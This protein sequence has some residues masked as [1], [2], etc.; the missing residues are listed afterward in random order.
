MAA[1][2]KKT[3]ENLTQLCRIKCTEAEQEKLLKDL[4]EIL[5]YVEQLQEVDTDHVKPCD[6][7]LEGIINVMREDVV[8]ETLPR[9]QF[10]ANA[11]SHIGGLIRVPP[12]I[13]SN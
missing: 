5:N 7:V 6:H 8:G 4:Q 9:E 1:L 11:P 12:V 2:D 13:K 10:L 3:I